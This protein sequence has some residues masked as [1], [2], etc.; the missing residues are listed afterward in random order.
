M[1]LS[2]EFLKPAVGRT[3]K[4]MRAVCA[5]HSCRNTLLIRTVPQSRTGITVGQLWY[6]SVDCFAQSARPRLSALSQG[7]IME[8]RHNP[9]LSIGLV[10]LS[11]DFLTVDQLRFAMA[12][13]QLHGEDVEAA[14]LRLGLA[15]ERQLAAAR[16]AQWG[17]PALGQDLTGRQVEADIPTA[18]LHACSA[19]PLHYSTT[20][21]RILLGVVS[22][23]DHSL[24]RSLE[25]ITGSRA[26]PCFIT[27]TEFAEQMERLIPVPDYEEKVFEDPRT[28]AQ[29]ARE[30]GGFAL[31]VAATEARF[32][33]CRNYIWTRLSGKRGMIDVLFRLES[34]SVPERRWHSGL[35][36]EKI[37]SLG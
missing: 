9:R 27:P 7:I 35:L 4:N 8:M 17:Y 32:A 3:W 10:M 14:V 22:R 16:A 18:V 29:M 20:A 6:C 21:K 13:S 26:E 28:P 19:V 37:G 33:Q 31:D 12:Q 2:F 23:V 30:L 36:E 25:E 1:K 5:L 34:A 24:L 15:N 11:K